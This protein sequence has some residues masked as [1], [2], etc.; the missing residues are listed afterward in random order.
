MLITKNINIDNVY[1]NHKDCIFYQEGGQI[2]SSG[3]KINNRLL[4]KT[5]KGGGDLA[6]PPGLFYQ[7]KSDISLPKCNDME[8]VFNESTYNKL[9]KL[10]GGDN[11]KQTRGRRLLD[12]AKR[13]TKRR[14]NW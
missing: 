12:K 1:M 8:E 14:G 9:Y 5:I 6:V 4:E 7:P 13:R 10:I 3:F 11:K 2:K